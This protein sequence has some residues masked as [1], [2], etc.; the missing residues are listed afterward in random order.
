MTRKYNVILNEPTPK[1]REFISYS[2]KRKIVRAGRRSGKTVGLSIYAVERFLAGKRVLYATPTAEQIERFWFEVCNALDEPVRAGVFEK[3]ETMHLIERARTEQRIRAKTAWNADTLRGDYGDEIIL[4]EYQLMEES[5]LDLV[6]FPMLLD[7]NGNLILSFTPPSLH[8]RSASKA[9]DKLHAIK[10]YRKKKGD[11]R[12]KCF[13]FTSYDNP[14]IS[15]EAIEE[16]SKDMTS[17]SIRLEIMAEDLDEAPGAIFKRKDID[18]GRVEECPEL[19]LLYVG[20]DPSG[21][22]AGNEAGIVAAGKRGEEY[23][24][25]EDNS[26]QALPAVWAAEAV[27]TFNFLKANKIVAETNYGGAMVEEIIRHEDSRITVMVVN[28]SRGKAIRAEPVGALY[29]HHKVHHVG[30]F[31]RLEDEM[32]IWE[33]GGPSPNRLDA[34]VWAIRALMEGGGYGVW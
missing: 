28:A 34:L 25:L 1:Q 18:E 8:S 4:D 3:N 33:P 24:V 17:M 21:S 20:V 19:D 6:V 12:W 2:S 16:I 10:F 26:L 9:K 11:P 29:E 14:H 22:S 31:E 5:A 32:C 7:N 30:K 27:R 23:Y 13:H 15:H